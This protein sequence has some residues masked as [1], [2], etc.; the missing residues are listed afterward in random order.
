[1]WMLR[2]RDS[3][4]KR[5]VTEMLQ[6]RHFVVFHHLSAERQN[7]EVYFAFLKLGALGKSAV[8]ALMVIYEQNIS[9]QSQGCTVAS[10]GAIGP[11]AGEAVHVLMQGASSSNLS[12]RCDSLWALGRLHLDFVVPTLTN[13][14]GDPNPE[15]RHAA[16][17]GLRNIGSPSSMDVRNERNSDGL[18]TKEAVTALLRSLHDSDATV[19][20]EAAIALR[21]IDPVAATNSPD[22]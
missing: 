6:K 15:V 11:P 1:L 10:L 19:R 12:L 3:P 22:N 13:A 18:W 21:Q 9:P 14:L 5:E 16:C 7:Q 17:V 20:D 2:Q 8:P 4:L